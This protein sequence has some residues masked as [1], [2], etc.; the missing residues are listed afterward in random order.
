MKILVTGGAGFIGSA[1]IRRLLTQTKHSVVNV[2]CL[3]YAGN[4][5]N[6]DGL[7]S[8]HELVRHDICDPSVEDRMD[9]V[10]E[11]VLCPRNKSWL[12]E[13]EPVTYCAE[14]E[15]SM[16]LLETAWP[17]TRKGLG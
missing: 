2:D 7:P 1:V 9:G 10:D 16:M 3:T 5:K 8:G 15:I 14:R 12:R 11:L 6:L 4:L 17:H 13:F